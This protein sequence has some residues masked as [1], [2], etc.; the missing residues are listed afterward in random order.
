MN[1]I[2]M[3][4]IFKEGGALNDFNPNYKERPMQIKGAKVISEGLSQS[5]NVLLEGECGFGKSYAYLFPVLEEIA[6]SGFLK[7]AVI[8]TSGIS[9]QEQL[10]TKDIPFAVKVMKSLHPEWPSDFTFTLLKGRQ[11]FLCLEKVNKL[12]LDTMPKNM[13]DSSYKGVYDF[14]HNTQTGDMSE[15]EFIPDQEIIKNIA[16]TQRGE[17][18]NRECSFYDNCYY[19]KHK[20]LLS[21][22]NVIITNYHMLF[23]DMKTGGK[24]LPQYEILVFDEAHE[25]AN[26]FRDFDSSKVTV[27][28]VM[29]LRNKA[30]ELNNLTDSY[31]SLLDGDMF[32]DI[33]KDFEIA[34]AD[35]EKM[36]SDL[37]SP[38][39]VYSRTDLPN[40]FTEL[41][42]G[43]MKINDAIG[44]ALTRYEGIYNITKSSCGEDSEEVK[45]QSKIGRVISTMES[46]CEDSLELIC[47]LESIL[48]NDNN[49]VWIDKV[50]E[51]VGM[52]H[53]KVEV[54]NALNEAFF[55]RESLTTIFTSATISVAG[56]FEYI[57][58]QLG[59][60]SSTK[61]TLEFIGGSPFNLTEQQLWY[62]PPNPMD[63]NKFGFDNTI[64]PN[65]MEIIES[66]GGGALC[67]FTSVK[68]MRNTFY[69]LR[70]NLGSQ[71]TIYVQ[72]DM[73][74]TKL[75]E[76]FKE[77]KNSVLL[78]TRSFFT[79]VDVPGD[80]LRA[81]I[82]DKFPF[83][84]PSDPVQQKLKDRDN[85]FYKYSIPEMIITL[86]QAIGRG[87]RSVD[88]KC[89]ISILDGRMSTARYKGRINNSF[90]YKKTGTRNIEDLQ[91]FRPVV[92]IG[93]NE[94]NDANGDYDDEMPF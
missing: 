7:S 78:G 5:A 57:K 71:Y 76:K 34:Y 43:M 68:N 42:E 26:I 19:T 82:I 21:R 67:L 18:L 83:P 55:S 90:D 86:K 46:M 4:D 49:V 25:A 60:K 11:N 51:Q 84:Q 32:K 1:K 91:K 94:W 70:R 65:M 61:P 44:S 59:L 85:S 40:S 10:Q 45:E 56:S 87:V 73:P 38:K 48:T 47:D 31:K 37:T 41:K 64:A 81:V 16:C 22:S 88:D 93:T 15:L 54:G 33:I 2:T 52:S 23:S 9:L 35:I 36:H 6:N 58:D 89:V 27:N 8:T 30:S 66:V 13:V 69:E 3:D 62:L 92:E 39:L 20:M 80:A 79:G 17:C 75:I 50:N 77:D 74:K 24:I 29:M 28:T 63:G 14:A 12:G 53:K 72:G